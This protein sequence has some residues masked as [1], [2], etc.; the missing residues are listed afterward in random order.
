MLFRSGI[1]IRRVSRS[2]EVMPGPP[3]ISRTITPPDARLLRTFPK[4]F[5]SSLRLLKIKNEKFPAT[6]RSNFPGLG[7]ITSCRSRLTRDLSL[8]RSLL[9][10][11]LR[12]YSSGSGSRSRPTEV[13]SGCVLTHWHESIPVPQ[14]S[15]RRRR[16][17]GLP[18]S[19]QICA[20][21]STW[22]SGL[23]TEPSYRWY[24]LG[25]ATTP[26]CT[27]EATRSKQECADPAG[28]PLHP[29]R[30]ETISSSCSPCGARKVTTSPTRAPWSA[31]AIGEI[32]LTSPR[33]GS[34]SS[35]P[36]MR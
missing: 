29:N 15:S 36:T 27:P 35:M 31:R 33:A 21:S 7:V 16:E 12:P 4:Y 24:L 10:C 28:R 34:A 22:A 20:S 26:T 19:E 8:R 25:V 30:T 1:V 5:R 2:G 23:W 18:T 6:T 14:K 32:Q 9:T 11:I 17:A 3:A 13:F